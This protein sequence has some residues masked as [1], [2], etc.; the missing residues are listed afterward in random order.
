MRT[1]LIVFF[2][3]I[4]LFNAKSFT[5]PDSVIFTSSN[6]PLVLINTNGQTIHNSYRIVAD[7]GIIN[8]P[9]GA[10]N[11]LT[12]PFTDYNGKISIEI[13][14]S[15]STMFDK[16][17]YGFETQD[18][19]GN[20]ANVSLLSMPKENDW[21]LYASY[22]DKTFLR[23]EIPYYLTRS[24]GIYASRTAYCELFIN[25]SYRGLYVLMEKIKQDKNRV[26]IAKLNPQDTTGIEL[27]GGYILKVDKPYDYGWQVNVNP[28]Y[29]FD[30]T[31]YQYHDPDSAELAPQQRA[32][33]KNFMFKVE[34]TLV[35]SN[36]ADTINGYAKYIDVESFVDYF[37]ISELVKSVDAYRF[38]FYMYKEKDDDGGKLHVG[39][40][41][42]Y[43]LA[44]AN[45]GENAWEQ[46]WKTS[47]WN[48]DIVAWKRTYF[49]KR[50]FSDQN[51]KNKLKERW[52]EIRNGAF[53]NSNIL[54]FMNE[55]VDSIREARIRNFIKWPIIGVYVWPNYF[56][57]A[58]YEDEVTFLQNWIVQRLLWMDTQLT[59][60][61][62]QINDDPN[63]VVTTFR[64]FQNYPNPFNPGTTISWQSPK[65]DWQTVKIYNSLGQE[66]E[67]IVNEYLEAGFH[68]KY[69]TLNST[70]SSGIYFYQLKSGSFIETKKMIM[71]K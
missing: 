53:S 44:F 31:Y 56:I 39:P 58:T 8:N 4:T 35:S 18:S 2:C 46:P 3:I 59:G 70:L 33:I 12:D 34:S 24:L 15:S 54:T 62:L 1:L 29:G 14:G 28:L 36:Y 5:E 25:G 61:P 22:S 60:A 65:S 27:T 66:V 10:R 49:M 43:D 55:T 48:A 42:D 13:R 30:K 50:L 19:A 7:M 57:G 11:H 68:S 47:D 45:Y 63:N 71:L 64:L 6:L 23:N 32:Y 20:N 37:L 38:S 21:V 41:W 52:I 16:K 17:P 51:F 40:I 26:D 69:Y 67:I 9:N